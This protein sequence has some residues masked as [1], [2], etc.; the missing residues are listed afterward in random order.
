MP[1]RHIWT[2]GLPESCRLEGV[3]FRDEWIVFKL[4]CRDEMRSLTIDFLSGKTSIR[5]LGEPEL[6][7]MVEHK[8]EFH[9]IFCY[10]GLKRRVWNK[11]IR[12]LNV[13]M[14]CRKDICVVAVVNPNYS[15]EVQTY[16]GSGDLLEKIGLGR[17]YHFDLVASDNI[18]AVT[19][20]GFTEE[21]TATILFDGSTGTVIDYYT[22]FG[23]YAVASPEMVF[24]MGKQD[25]IFMT[26]GY[27]NDGEEMINDE[28]LPVLPPFNPIPLPV[29]GMEGYEPRIIALMDRHEIKVYNTID[30]SIDYTF[31]RP[32]FTRG[33]FGIDEYSTTV[34]SSIMGNSLIINYDLKGRVKWASHLVRD[35]KYAVVSTN[36][37]AMYVERE[38]RGETRLYSINEDI[39]KH[40]ETFG[41]NAKPIMARRSH[42]VL[43]D[44]RVVAAYAM[45]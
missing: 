14:I 12:G 16:S 30:Y 32:P 34:L 37:V 42:I 19:S 35:L 28:G 20:A 39:L 21:G 38:G 40:E 6:R 18:I 4:Y 13:K 44:G 1:I 36:L 23:G 7:G 3:G 2:R 33:L 26:R 9:T 15:L 41:P 5:S 31:I 25:D 11:I 8:R 43:T 22:G 17:I 10:K 45:E 29:Q 27:N 24:I